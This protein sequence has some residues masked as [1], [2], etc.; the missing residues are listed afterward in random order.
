MLGSGAWWFGFEQPQ[1]KQAAAFQVRAEVEKANLAAAA[2]EAKKQQEAAQAAAQAEADKK[3]AADEARIAAARQELITETLDLAQKAL[4]GRQWSQADSLADKLAS[5]DPQNSQIAGIRDASASGR[6]KERAAEERARAVPADLPVSGSFNLAET[7][8]PSAYASFN[9]FTQSQIL[10]LAQEKLKSAGL[11]SGANDGASGEATTKA[12]ISFQRAAPA[13]AVTGR[14]DGETLA[15]L[16]LSGLAE[17]PEPTPTPR[18]VSTPR[19]KPASTPKPQAPA[20]DGY[21]KNSGW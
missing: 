6:E 7:F 14:L 8:A 13:L 15:A 9:G 5:L 18:P 17:M 11:Y 3:K 2:A 16:G 12:I 20:N 21:F 19:P 4:Q 1:R 10:K